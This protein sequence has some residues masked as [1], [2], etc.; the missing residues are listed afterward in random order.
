MPRGD[1]TSDSDKGA[2]EVDTTASTSGAVDKALVHLYRLVD[3]RRVL[4]GDALP[5]AAQIAKEVNVN[6]VAVLQALQT[7]QRQGL[8]SIKR[9][10]GGARVIGR[11]DRPHDQRLARAL[12]KKK[13]LGQVALLRQILDSGIAR[14]VATNG[15][16]RSQ[17]KRARRILEELRRINDRDRYLALDTEFHEILGD[18]TGSP[19]LKGLSL[20]LRQLV[21]VGLDAV[22]LPPNLLGNSNHEH[23]RLLAAIERGS[24]TSAADWGHRH[25]AHSTSLID[26]ILGGPDKPAVVG[27]TTERIK[28]RAGHSGN[29]RPSRAKTATS[30]RQQREPR[31]RTGKSR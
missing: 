1:H 5:P 4:P 10:R 20:S 29:G 30:G 19:V 8:I 7:L 16:P 9:G 11:D 24:A 21:L 15:L 2:H 27:G 12:E 13:A 14:T 26:H 28:V 23:E 31:E 17:M 6:R 25:S 18:A 3:L 22:E